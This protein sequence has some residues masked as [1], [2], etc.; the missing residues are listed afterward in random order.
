MS[1]SSN[2]RSTAVIPRLMFTCSGHALAPS[3]T[4]QSSMYR[5]PP[6]QH[7]PSAASV[8][9]QHLPDTSITRP[10]PL[11]LEGNDHTRL[12]ETKTDENTAKTWCTKRH[13]HPSTCCNSVHLCQGHPWHWDNSTVPRSINL[14][15]CVRRKN[16]NDQMNRK[17]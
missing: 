16:A 7:R 9:L 3:H 17:S 4:P 13:K 10:L 8:P 12:V 11:L 5:P 1:A 6:L 14:G 15:S 2:T